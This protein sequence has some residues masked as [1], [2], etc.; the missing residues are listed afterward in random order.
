MSE[1]RE[2]LR[3]SDNHYWVE[4]EEEGVVR[5]GLSDFGQTLFGDITAI[6]LPAE[7]D[8]V[9]AD[10]GIG[11]I[12]SEE[13][14]SEIFCPVSG[15]VVEVNSALEETPDLINEDPYGDGWLFLVHLDDPEELDKLMTATEYE[16]FLENEFGEE[17]EDLEEEAF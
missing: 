11:E 8:E 4:V 6:V 16:D 12:E 13:E 7:A 15:S 17:E 10:G 5:I 9:E 1:V 2:G 3:Y 14:Q